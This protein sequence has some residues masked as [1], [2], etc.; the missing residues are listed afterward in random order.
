MDVQLSVP[1]A[2]FF[3][4]AHIMEVDQVQLGKSVDLHVCHGAAYY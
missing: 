3:S 1:R 4:Y 2:P